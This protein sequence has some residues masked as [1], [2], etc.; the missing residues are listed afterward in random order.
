MRPCHLPPPLIL[1]ISLFIALLFLP[2]YGECVTWVPGTHLT[3]VDA[4]YD[5][6]QVQLVLTRLKDAASDPSLQV[7]LAG[8]PLFIGL[9]R[10]HVAGLKLATNSSGAYA[11]TAFG[12]VSPSADRALGITDN[13]IY[14]GNLVLGQLTPLKLGMSYKRV[15][16]PVH[17]FVEKTGADLTF[18]FSSRLVGHA[19]SDFDMER[20]RWRDQNY[21]LQFNHRS[22]HLK[23]YFQS[24]YMQDGPDRWKN[25]RHPLGFLQGAEA[26]VAITGL[27]ADWNVGHRMNLGARRRHYDYHRSGIG[28]AG[29]TAGLFA[30]TSATGDRFGLEVGRMDGN[31]IESRYTLYCAD[32]AWRRPLDW[33]GS[34]LHVKTYLTD[35]EAPVNG[36]DRALRASLGAVFTFLNGRLKAELAGTYKDDPYYEDHFGFMLNT[37]LKYQ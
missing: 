12:G 30:V 7:N 35:F 13:L 36:Q 9:T 22:V 25:E 5:D 37:V 26:Q 16:D 29:Y 23:P 32:L 3:A 24:F 31:A 2:A 1:F 14:G 8:Q 28:Y 21:S 10:E 19:D 34:Q 11:V 4:E 17:T 33:A 27:D 15:Q 20:H 6:P 18:K